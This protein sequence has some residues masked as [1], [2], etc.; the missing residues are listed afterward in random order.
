[1]IVPTSP[2]TMAKVRKLLH[3][4]AASSCS[5]RVGGRHTNHSRTR[6]E[7]HPSSGSVGDSGQGHR[8]LEQQALVPSSVRTR[9]MSCTSCCRCGFP[10]SRS[11]LHLMLLFDPVL[12]PH[13][14]RGIEDGVVGDGLTFDGTNLSLSGG[15]IK[16]GGGSGYWS[17]A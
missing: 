15:C 14:L 9:C 16:S 3:I 10:I 2:A 11:L 1:M 8:R 7:S 5:R 17:Q 4:I 6:Q 12:Q 13:Q